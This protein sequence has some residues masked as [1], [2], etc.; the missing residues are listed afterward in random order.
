MVPS[1]VLLCNNQ[2]HS[3]P[4]VLSETQ[5]SRRPGH[6]P[7]LGAAPL[8]GFGLPGSC[9]DPGVSGRSGIVA[10]EALE[11]TLETSVHRLPCGV[12][13]QQPR[14][15]DLPKRSS[16]V[17]CLPLSVCNFFFQ[18]CLMISCQYKLS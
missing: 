2:G 14:L 18:F 11:N 3:W 7:L 13:S 5:Q 9:S 17:M 6:G 12:R 4:V 10:L 8:H 1:D 15:Q 16:A